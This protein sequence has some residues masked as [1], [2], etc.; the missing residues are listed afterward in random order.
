MS[1]NSNQDKNKLISDIQKFIVSLSNLSD[2]FE[3]SKMTNL[4]IQNMIDVNITSL[5]QALTPG[6][7]WILISKYKNHTHVHDLI[8]FGKQLQIDFLVKT[9]DG[10]SIFQHTIGM[11]YSDNRKQFYEKILQIC[12][13]QDSVKCMEQLKGA[14]TTNNMKIL[15]LNNMWKLKGKSIESNFDELISYVSSGVQVIGN[16]ISTTINFSPVQPTYFTT[17]SYNAPNLTITGQGLC[18]CSDNNKK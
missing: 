12:F 10:K 13:E 8:D 18:I 6:M 3:G 17:G 14:T 9:E 5:K 2:S 7:F 4:Y 1:T 16:G 15:I 11:P